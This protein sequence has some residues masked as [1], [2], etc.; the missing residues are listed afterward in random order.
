MPAM[1]LDEYARCDAVELARLV[2]TR[3]VQA[4]EL[5]AL[6]VAGMEKLQPS[7]NF[8]AHDLVPQAR[9]LV[10]DGPVGPFAGVPLMLKDLALEMKDTPYEAGCRLLKGN[11]SS[12]D[13]N[14][15]R[16]FRAA[17]LVTVAKTTCAEFGAQLG[18][19]TILNGITR[20]PWSLDHTPGG[21][22]GGSAAAVAAGVVPVAHA[23]DGIG[24]I[25]IPAANCGLFGLKPNRQ[26]LPM[27]PFIGDAPGSRGVEFVLTRTVRDAA[28]L[29]DALH[30]GDVGAPGIA[31]APVRPYR[32][33]LDRPR[34]GLRIALMTTSFSGA[35]VHS[36]CSR[37]V[38]R[39]ALVCES[40]G[41]SVEVARPVFD[42]AAFR[43]AIRLE[44]NANSA[45]SL[46]MVA[47]AVGR[48]IGP[49]TLEPFTLAIYREGLKA[50]AVDY[51]RTHFTYGVIQ[52][53]V[54]RFF[55][56]YDILLTPMLSRPTAEI[57]WLGQKPEDY[58]AF[59]ERFSG[60]A[61]SP[62]AGLFNVTG[63]PA[64]SIPSLMTENG[65][66]IGTQMVG[67]FGDEGTLLN[68]AA[69]LEIAEPW[70]GRLPL[71]HVSH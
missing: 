44:S 48:E 23:N 40:L 56:D 11:V 1:N 33:E 5:L 34:K 17:G 26:R 35:P 49:D 19:E 52:R 13:S 28:H 8:V 4:S 46:E 59:W 18:T 70:I 47:R 64:A 3:E 7:L 29:L 10:R 39:T 62:F 16:Q 32:D 71:L 65:L 60:D 38:E 6:A 50:S 20:N 43:Q 57:G 55:E 30:G 22:S 36:A 61:Y 68:L 54:G 24:S 31:P 51:A 21:S 25:R 42:H 41:H 15:M 2:Q 67:R 14:L 37:A 12:T 63:Q 9:E 53:Q 27:G 45:A 58:E 66:P 69:Q